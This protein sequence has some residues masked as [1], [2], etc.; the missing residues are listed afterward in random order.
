MKVN[1]K[2]YLKMLEKTT[3]LEDWF[4]IYSF[5]KNLAIKKIKIIIQT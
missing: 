2:N 3:D 4:S 1:F 5:G